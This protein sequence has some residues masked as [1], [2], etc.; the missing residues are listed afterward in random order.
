[1]LQRAPE[2]PYH[3]PKDPAVARIGGRKYARY[4]NEVFSEVYAAKMGRQPLQSLKGSHWGLLFM[5]IAGCFLA[6]LWA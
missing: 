4:D 2:N 1:M 3:L 6:K 5:L